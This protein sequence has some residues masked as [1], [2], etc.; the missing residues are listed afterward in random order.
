MKYEYKRFM[1]KDWIPPEYEVRAKHFLYIFMAFPDIL[2]DYLR[3][4]YLIYVKFYFRKRRIYQK[5][6]KVESIRCEIII[7]VCVCGTSCMAPVLLTIYM[8]HSP[9]TKGQ[10]NLAK[11][12]TVKF[13]L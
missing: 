7:T 9:F 1:A 12:C 8:E 4:V 5:R 11:H 3:H 2:Y 13:F 6:K 10:C